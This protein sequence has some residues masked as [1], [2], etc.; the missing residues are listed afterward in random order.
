[1]GRKFIFK[2][3]EYGNKLY[4]PVFKL[5]GQKEQTNNYNLTHILTENKPI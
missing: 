2:I 4:Y 1:M 3:Y 5:E